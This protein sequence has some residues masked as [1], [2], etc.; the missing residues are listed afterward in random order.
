MPT[1]DVF[2][3]HRPE[4]FGLAYRMLGSV[5]DAE[6]ILQGV[7]LRW[8]NAAEVDNRSARVYLTTIVTGL[9]IDHLRLAHVQ[10]EHYVG[11]W[12]PEPLLQS[13]ADNP[14]HIVK[15]D[16][17]IS[18]A[19]LLRL[20][21]LSP[22]DRAV[23]LLHDVFNYTFAEIAT[24][25]NRNPAHC[26]Q[27]G[28]RARWR[29]EQNCPRF[30]VETAT[31]ESVAQQFIRACTS[32]DMHQLFALLAPDVT[33]WTDSGGKVR[34]VRNVIIGREK[35]A[36]L[37]LGLSRKWSPRMAPYLAMV[38]GQPAVVECVGKGTTCVTTFAV[39]GGKI[40]ALYRV[41]NPDKLRDI[42]CAQEQNGPAE[43]NLEQVD[44]DDQARIDATFRRIMGDM[45][46]G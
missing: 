15:M 41:L 25:V 26:R 9:C 24:I 1:V 7:F 23:F 29:L 14:Q 44:A 30:D 18:T 10:R 21:N 40:H 45:E 39:S 28:H 8:Q 4:L 35:V 42:D 36:R 37:L 16:E 13:S 17:S 19:F 5:T 2:D 34:A 6:E 46:W 3:R 33:V 20:D 12:L 38:N 22:L 11:A 31:V 43:G 27:I 32:G